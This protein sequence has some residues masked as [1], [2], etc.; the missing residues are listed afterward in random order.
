MSN[1]SPTPIRT[2]Q[3][4]K[5]LRRMAAVTMA[6]GLAWGGVACSTTADNNEPRNPT[7]VN[8]DSDDILPPAEGAPNA[9][10]VG[11]DGMN[12]GGY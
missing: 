11:M 3:P 5:L 9:P 1:A 10:G 4:S 2:E 12:G 6:V 7:D 8:V